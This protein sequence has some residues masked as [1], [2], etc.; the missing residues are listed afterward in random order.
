MNIKNKLIFCILLLTNII[1]NAQ[2]GD[3]SMPYSLTDYYRNSSIK[4]SKDINRIF[5]GAMDNSN[6]LLKDSLFQIE[7]GL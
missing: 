6:L 2:I 3:G 7:N 5:V 1:V 4:K